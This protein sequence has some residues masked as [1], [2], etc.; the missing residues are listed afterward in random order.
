MRA[1]SANE[2]EICLHLSRTNRKYILKYSFS[3]KFSESKNFGKMRAIK[4]TPFADKDQNFPP[5]FQ[6]SIKFRELVLASYFKFARFDKV[7]TPR[8]L[9]NFLLKREKISKKKQGENL[10]W[11]FIRQKG[12]NSFTG[13][14]LRDLAEF[15]GY[16]YVF[17][18]VFHYTNGRKSFH[19]VSSHIGAKECHISVPAAYR[20]KITDDSLI[21][22]LPDLNFL[23]NSEALVE[24]VDSFYPSK[25]LPEWVCVKTG[26]SVES[27]LK[28]IET[29]YGDRI[30]FDKERPF[31][32]TFG[33]GYQ[34]SYKDYDAKC[35]YTDRATVVLKKS[36]SEN[37]LNLEFIDKPPS[38]RYILMTDMFVINE[39][40]EIYHCPNEWCQIP[41]N[42]RLDVITDH[43]K[44]CTN[45]T[46][47]TYETKKM[48]ENGDVRKFLEKNNFISSDFSQDH[49]SVFDIECLGVTE[50]AGPMS[51]K[52]S[53]ISDQK[54]VTVAFGTTFGVPSKVISR[55]S[56]SEADYN[57]FYQEVVRHIFFMANEYTQTLPSCISES[58]LKIQEI[59]EK[60]RKSESSNLDVYR[61]TMLQKSLFYLKQ[62]SKLRIYGY[63]SEKYDQP[64]ILPGILSVLKLKP[65]DT[66]VITRGTGVMMLGLDIWDSEVI[67]VDAYNLSGG[68][69]L[70]KFAK[71]MG[72]ETSKGVF[73]YEYFQS[74]T[75]MKDCKSFPKYE[76]FKSSL[77]FPDRESF[78]SQFRL[79]FEKAHHD[80][81]MSADQYLEQMSIPSSSYELSHDPSQLPESIDFSSVHCT[82]DP[83]AYVENLIEFNFL[84]SN[85][86]ID[87]M[88][89]FLCLYNKKDIDILKEA[90]LKFCDLFKQNLNINPLEYL[91]LPGLAET[92]LWRFFDDSKGSPFSLREKEINELIRENNFGGA[93][94]IIG[95]RHQEIGVDPADRIYA[96]KVYVTPNGE[97]IKKA[98]SLDFNNL[99]GHGKRMKLPVGKAM[100]YKRR[101]D[102]FDWSPVSSSDNYSLDSIEW[103]NYKQSEFLK[104]DGTRHVIAH[105]LNKGEVVI[106]DDSEDEE[107]GILKSKM[108]K[109]D[110]MVTVDGVDHFF[111][112]DGCHVHECPH[113]CITFRRNISS[114]NKICPREIE[115]RNRFYRSRGQLHTITSCEWYKLRQ[116]VTFKNYTSS[117]FRSKNI[118][119]RAILEKIAKDEFFG[120][121]LVDIES[122]PEVIRRFSEVGFGT[123]FRHME[124]DE[125]MIHPTYLSKL[126][127]LK[128]PFPL[129]KVLTL[130]F[131]AKSILITTELAKFYMSLGMKLSNL[132]EALEYECDTPLANFVN[133]VTE[134]RKKATRAG[135]TALQSVFK[136]VANR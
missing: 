118:T 72:A 84:T 34:I 108:Y 123:I 49:F 74:V 79:G 89:D 94:I 30:P 44:I 47:Y 50:N 15:I 75:E 12:L 103:I 116:R 104:E 88:L 113:N 136:L 11:K 92:I 107:F 111:E 97:T 51:A 20:F 18:A 27:V 99:Y 119:E 1:G 101:G 82:L 33:L 31:L 22:K 125:S 95:E 106:Y 132:T 53:E 17:W 5:D 38:R 45:E 25:T 4:L 133:T 35:Q 76:H 29:I 41:P 128:R 2:S 21:E 14:T 23:N 78:D 121:I 59:L 66:D 37:F 109:P 93:T 63:N 7:L 91:S 68:G 131:H 112:F 110:G 135:N 32:N 46:K 36:N 56:F 85:L 65:S 48:T 77:R 6:K 117:F 98:D 55:N 67:F 105:A 80:L 39:K 73:P 90:L 58:I 126:K 81:E 129:D 26:Q 69:S 115:D 19:T 40:V 83:L 71:M 120:L 61:K 134:E 64:L 43:I 114:P 52:C 122:P 13:T 8:F 9:Q 127:D 86:V 124:V 24:F 16:D 3:K 28:Q 60:E 87:N 42:S 100:H 57:K 10:F 62:V 130:A 102:L 54:I 96:E 70:A